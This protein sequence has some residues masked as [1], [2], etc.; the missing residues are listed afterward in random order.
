[1]RARVWDVVAQLGVF[2]AVII[3]WQLY[4]TW[5]QVPA[6]VLPGPGPVWQKLVSIAKNGTLWRH[7][8]MTVYEIAVGFG[9]GTALGALVGYFLAQWR[10]L[11]EFLQ[12]YI[13]FAQTAPKIALIP[14]FVIWFGLGMTSKIVLIVSSVFFPVMV[15]T[16]LG[17]RSVPAELNELLA[18]LKA[19]RWQRLFHIEIP[20]AFP[21]FMAGLRLAIIQAT[22]AAI[23]AEWIAGDV[24]L[25]FLLVYGS[26]TYD[27]QLL[28]AAVVA[29]NVVGIACY[30]A[31]LALERRL[32]RWQADETA[33]H[34]ENTA[35]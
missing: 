28:L 31:L 26:T 5:G 1:M 22:I 3:G 17:L 7:T 2:A 24:G 12:P 35:A 14:L 25:G 20:S 15:N 9:L 33:A 34:L 8:A 32:L 10:A 19:S 11:E 21:L 29:T 16:I 4:V 6:F 18:L 27:A 13:L 30:L 23:V